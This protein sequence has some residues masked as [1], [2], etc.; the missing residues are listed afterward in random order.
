MSH[1]NALTRR[2]WDYVAG[3]VQVT[4]PKATTRNRRQVH[5]QLSYTQPWLGD[6]P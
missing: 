2:T 3:L 1:E 6:Q 5:E 4:R